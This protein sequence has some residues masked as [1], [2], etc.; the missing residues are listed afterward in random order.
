MPEIFGINGLFQLGIAPED[1][2]VQHRNYCQLS[3]AAVAIVSYII[4]A[5]MSDF[6]H[7]RWPVNFIMAAGCILSAILILI[8]DIPFAAKF[9]AFSLAGIGYAGHGSNFAWANDVMRDDDQERAM[10]LA[11]MNLWSNVVNSWW[12]IVLYPATGAPR[13]KKGMIA[14]ICV[15]VSFCLHSESPTYRLG[16]PNI[17]VLQGLTH[18]LQCVPTLIALETSADENVRTTA[19][20]MHNHLAQKHGSILAARYPEHARVAFNFQLSIKSA[21]QLRGSRMEDRPTAALHQWYSLVS[22]KRQTKLDFLKSMIK[23]FD[24][25]RF[26]EACTVEHV[27]F[28]RFMADNLA[29][30]DYTTNE[31]VMTV[32]GELRTILSLAGMQAYSAIDDELEERQKELSNLSQ[33]PQKKAVEIWAEIETTSARPKRGL[34]TA[35]SQ[36]SQQATSQPVAASDKILDKAREL[37]L[38]WTSTILGFALLLRNQLKWMY[39]LSEARCAK[40]VPGKKTSAGADKP[41][42]RRPLTTSAAAVLELGSLP[43][44]FSSCEQSHDALLQ[45]QAYHNAIA[46]EGSIL[47]ADEGDTYD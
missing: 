3:L 22:E 47:E 24:T 18:P 20:R 40:Y 32:V 14:L 9:F 36:P 46:E 25:D 28:A 17:T 37:E 41:A 33:G 38:A 30:F 4:Y 34:P 10:V 1:T 27:A 13:F 8:W 31:E 2:S 16:D 15:A 5:H 42:V 39:T 6:Y 26:E 12:S 43:G 21:D 11:S 23:A 29:V 7:C 45:M 44:A 19:F 35:T